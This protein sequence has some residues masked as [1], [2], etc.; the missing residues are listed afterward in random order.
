MGF[1]SRFNRGFKKVEWGIDTEKM[2]FKKCSELEVGKEYPLLGCFVTPDRGYGLGAVLITSDALI[3][4]PNRYVEDINAIQDNVEAV[5]VIK[6]GHMGFKVG[7]FES[8]QFHRVGY[9]IE[10]TD[11]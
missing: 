2:K 5:E 10:F 9:N 1:A 6:S 11:R 8:K 3:N 7:K 4:I